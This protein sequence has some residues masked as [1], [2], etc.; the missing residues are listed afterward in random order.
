MKIP[1]K[2]DLRSRINNIF[3]QNTYLACYLVYGSELLKA[4]YENSREIKKS[5]T[6][7]LIVGLVSEW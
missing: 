3:I 1:L 5:K 7:L 2:S 4:Q 6:N